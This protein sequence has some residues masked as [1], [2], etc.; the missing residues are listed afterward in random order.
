M[1]WR[2]KNSI[3]NL[4]VT[5]EMQHGSKDKAN[6]V[7]MSWKPRRDEELMRYEVMKEMEDFG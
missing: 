6:L 3:K 2:R 5:Q 4:K 1:E 7:I